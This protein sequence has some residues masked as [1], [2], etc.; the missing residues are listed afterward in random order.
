MRTITRIGTAV[1]AGAIALGALG[2]APAQADGQ[3]TTGA[4]TTAAASAALGGCAAVK[5]WTGRV[6]QSVRV[7][8]NCS[9]T[10]SFQVK[11]RGPDPRCTVLAP[12]RS[13]TAQWSRWGAQWQGIRWNCA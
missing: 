3:A 9:Y 7:T 1:A 2:A 4:Q 11:R 8:N 12:H 5:H 6:T 13:A 10:I